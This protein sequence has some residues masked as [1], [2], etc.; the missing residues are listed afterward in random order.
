MHVVPLLLLSGRCEGIAIGKKKSLS[1]VSPDGRLRVGPATHSAT[2]LLSRDGMVSEGG[3]IMG[4]PSVGERET[5]G[6][7]YSMV[8]VEV[9]TY[10]TSGALASS[11]DALRADSDLQAYRR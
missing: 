11:R 10:A 5:L 7:D 1:V 4:Q 6:G 9:A 3:G 8:M 2:L